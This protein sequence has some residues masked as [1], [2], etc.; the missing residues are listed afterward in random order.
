MMNIESATADNTSKEASMAISIVSWILRLAA[1]V[2]LLQTLFFKFSAAPESVYIFTKLGAEPWGRIGS[3]VIE[4]IAAVLLLTPRFTWLGSLLAMGVMAGAILSHLTLLGIQVQGD[5]GL[6]FALAV[7]VFVA[8]GVN[9]L[10]HRT[11]I[12]IIGRKLA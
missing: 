3:G 1:I 2:I 5:K 8:A 7:I 11:E 10:L 6:L 4:L 9:L 12:P